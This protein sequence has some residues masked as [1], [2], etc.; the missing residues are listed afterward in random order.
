M[1]NGFMPV[2]WGGLDLGSQIWALGFFFFAAM[3][4]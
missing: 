3:L 2:V 4:L 1:E